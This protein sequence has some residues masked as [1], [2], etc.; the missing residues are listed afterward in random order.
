MD[1][2]I[3]LDHVKAAAEWAL[4]A[5]EPCQIDGLTRRYAQD[6]WDCDTSCC[7]W[8]A[9]SILAGN[10]PASAGPPKEW[11]DDAQKKLVAALLNSAATCPRQIL[12]I[13]A[14]AYLSE[15]YL[16]EADLSEADLRG[17]NLSKAKLIIGNITVTIA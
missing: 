14:K 9:A 1:N 6:S 7:M 11:A 5:Q 12:D 17:A 15:A 4:T 16:S 13:I 2:P 8:G 3:T 10:G